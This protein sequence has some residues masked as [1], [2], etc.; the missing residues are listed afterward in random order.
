MFFKERKSLLETI[1]FVVD[2]DLC[3]C[4]DKAS[5]GNTCVPDLFRILYRCNEVSSYALRNTGKSKPLLSEEITIATRSNSIQYIR[6]GFA[7]K[8]YTYC[9]EH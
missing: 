9:V 7:C 6:L 5:K 3:E 2:F 4:F 8:S 1:S